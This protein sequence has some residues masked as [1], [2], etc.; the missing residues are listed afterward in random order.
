MIVL[1]EKFEIE[2]EPHFSD[3]QREV[4]TREVSM[5]GGSFI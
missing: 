1:L 5:R 4:S 2:T 3:M